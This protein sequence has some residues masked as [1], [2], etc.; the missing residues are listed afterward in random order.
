[1]R[2]FIALPTPDRAAESILLDTAVLR[3][4]Y[5]DLKWVRQDAL[6]LTLAFLGEVEEE[7]LEAIYRAMDAAGRMQEP[8]RLRYAGLG[9]FPRRG[10]PRVLFLP[11][12][13]GGR[14]C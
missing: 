1:M 8:F 7:N 13:E 12:T 4:K 14:E 6:H 3:G 11:V 10:M 2:L 9:T 5:P